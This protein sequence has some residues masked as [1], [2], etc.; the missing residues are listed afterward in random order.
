MLTEPLVSIITVVYN[1]EKTL[2]QTL[3]SVCEQTYKNIEYIVIDGGSSDGTVDIIKKYS[4]DIAY[5][6]SE[7]DGGIYY[8]FNKALAMAKGELIGIINSDDWYEKNAVECVVKE[9]LLCKGGDVFHGLLRFIGEGDKPDSVV[10]HYHTFLSNGM[11]EHPTCFVKKSLYDSIG[12][13]D[14]MYRSAADYEFM[15]RARKA[16]ARFVFVTQ[17]LANFRRGGISDSE[18]GFLEELAIKRRYGVISKL[19]YIKW[20]LFVKVRKYLQS[21]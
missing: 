12:H 11:I 15:Q 4:S 19:K 7:K 16:G 1:S 9:Y 5:W 14:T 18:V 20:K 8:A 17:L 6:I 10:G 3:Q 21:N 13:F 2:E